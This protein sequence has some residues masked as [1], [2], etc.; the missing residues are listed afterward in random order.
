[1]PFI[2]SQAGSYYLTGNLS[3]SSATDGI[4][5]NADNVTIDLNGFTLTGFGV[6][7]SAIYAASDRFNIAIRNG[8]V[9]DWG[10]GV[11]LPLTIN[12][13]FENLRLYNNTANFGLRTSHTCTIINCVARG[14]FDGIVTNNASVLKNCVS[15]NNTSEGII[16]GRVCVA[17]DCVTSGNTDAGLIAGEACM[18]QNCSA[19]ANTVDGIRASNNCIL[20][21]NACDG[22]GTGGGAGIHIP[23]GVT[24]NRIEQNILTNN[25][26]G[27]YVEGTGN[28][29]IKNTA[30]GNGPTNNS[31][32]FIAADNRYGQVVNITAG[33]TP[34]VTG[35]VAGS[36]VQSADPWANFAY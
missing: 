13:Q 3:V 7:N 9:R 10:A 18:V 4:T 15:T 8:T 11:N 23:S 19:S 14:N 17:A 12:S 6:A 5:I 28:L 24:G 27:I 31:D 25:N 35:N 30:R 34:A 2:I 22:N 36:T 33:S 26:R 29:I 1:L 16:L 21:N 32:Y 20:L